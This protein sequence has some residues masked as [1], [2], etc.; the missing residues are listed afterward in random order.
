MNPLAEL[1]GS[2]RFRLALLTLLSVLSVMLVYSVA[3]YV[4]LDGE[5]RERFEKRFRITASQIPLLPP[6]GGEDLADA[7]RPL[8]LRDVRGA[9]MFAAHWSGDRGWEVLLGSWPE[10]LVTALTRE[11]VTAQTLDWPV[12]RPVIGIQSRMLD[13]A[14]LPPAR[15]R[16]PIRDLDLPLRLPMSELRGMRFQEI[17]TGRSTWLIGGVRLPDG[18]LWVA[19]NIDRERA[20]LGDL[21]RAQ[22]RLG[23]VLLLVALVLSWILATRALRPVGA[24]SAAMGRI[25][26]RNLDERLS[27]RGAATEFG[28][29][30]EV[31]N[32][33]LARLERSFQQASRFSADASHELRTPLTVLQGELEAAVQQTSAGSAEQEQFSS[34]LEEVQ[35]LRVM[36]DRLLQLAHA[37]A[38]CLIRRREAIDFSALVDEQVEVVSELAPELDV[39]PDLEP[40]SLEGDSE[41]LRQ[42]IMNLL[43]NAHKY[44]R[45]GGFVDI[46]LRGTG[47]FVWLRVTN[48]GRPIPE[49]AQAHVFDRFFR[50]DP[51]RNRAVDG[52][53]LGLS[54]AREIARAHG[55]DL[56]LIESTSEGTAFELMLPQ[57]PS[58]IT[59]LAS[60]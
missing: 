41:L 12:A 52:L 47:D 1:W 33:M 8:P 3:T 17:S 56:F 5:I 50:G 25:S 43:T 24:L 55:G 35:R 57:S 53:G 9:R 21:V 30:I 60:T 27:P 19:E 42:A 54:L 13:G 18:V 31:F 28:A 49:E 36:T 4:R 14:I 7:S 40:T 45:P 10:E 37:D 58:D 20:A 2:F 48:S 16:F 11:A 15:Q 23:P 34:L 51:A 46:L 44:N 59:T 29:L 6:D 32:R 38:G 26:E 22:A 39:R